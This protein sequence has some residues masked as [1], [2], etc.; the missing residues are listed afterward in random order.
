MLGHTQE[1]QCF[2]RVKTFLLL[3]LVVLGNALDSS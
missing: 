3:Q 2:V 1:K